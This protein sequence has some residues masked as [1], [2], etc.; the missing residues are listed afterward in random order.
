MSA[1]NTVSGLMD[2]RVDGT[3]WPSVGRNRYTTYGGVSG[4][5]I[6][7]LGLRAVTAIAK[8]LPGFPIFGI[9]GVDSANVA[10]QYLRGGASAVQV[11]C[12]WLMIYNSYRFGLGNHPFLKN[13][14]FF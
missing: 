14:F 8:A 2:T 3:P 1:I 13:N 10:L 11:L 7:P 6:R 4:N 9:G 12:L 5:A